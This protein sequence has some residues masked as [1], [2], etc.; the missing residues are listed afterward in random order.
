M[1]ILNKKKKEL[2]KYILNIMILT[3]KP[4]I[5]SSAVSISIKAILRS[6]SKNLN[7]FIVPY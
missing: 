1:C 2:K 5:A 7:R 3:I 4:A 6:F